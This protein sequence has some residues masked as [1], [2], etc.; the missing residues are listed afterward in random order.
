[1]A[2]QPENT[3]PPTARYITTHSPHT[4]LSI[5]SRFH[6]PS[7]PKTT[8]PNGSSFTLD[9]TTSTTPVSYTADA[10]I[11]AY[12]NHLTA[13]PPLLPAYATPNGTVIRHTETP[14]GGCTP[15]HRTLTL[16]YAAVLE[17]E[18]DLILDSGEVRRLKRGD[19]VIQ[20]GTMHAWRNASQTEWVRMLCVLM[21][22]EE[23]WE[24]NG[25]VMKMEFRA[26]PK[27]GA[28]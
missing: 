2:P 11:A 25:E 1:M 6:D 13:H 9:Y 5:F 17:G 16:D 18:V 3:L 23:G 21:P 28:E 27:N 12:N 10:D 20:R 24:V 4:G 15:M 19:T 26:P 8:L 22:I 7:V 14:P